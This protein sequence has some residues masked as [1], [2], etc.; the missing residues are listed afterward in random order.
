VNRQS[1]PSTDSLATSFESTETPVA[2]ERTVVLGLSAALYGLLAWLCWPTL[3]YALNAHGD[4]SWFDTF[5]ALSA[6]DA[7]THVGTGFYRPGANVFFWAVSH[8]PNVSA[9]RFIMLA[10]FL[11][12]VGYVQLDATVRGRSYVDGFGAALA[13]S[14]TPSALSV[15]CWL[16]AAPVSLCA[17]AILAY[18]A[19]A[20][21]AL[22]A[23]SPR[24]RDVW[25]ALGALGV[26]LCFY[27][28]AIFA[29]L[30]VVAYQRLLAPR[31]C[32]RTARWLHVG[33]AC[34]VALYLLAQTLVANA[35]HFWAHE[36]PLPLL[37]SS[38][39]Y[40]MENYYLFFNPFDTFGVSIPDRSGDHTTENAV[41]W[42]LMAGGFAVVW[43]CRKSDPLAAFSGLWFSIFLLPVGS[44]FHFEG[45]PIAEQHLY[46]PLMGVAVGGVRLFTRA[47][48][49][50]VA[51]I[52]NKPLRVGVEC[53]I[54]VGLL[55][56]LAPLV[57][58]CTSIVASWKD[59]TTLYTATLAHYPDNVEV[60]RA[61]TQTVSEQA[62][63]APERAENNLTPSPWQ[64]AL[65]KLLMRAEPDTAAS[66][67]R[68]GQTLL[69]GDQYTEASSA[70]SRAFVVSKTRRDQL[71]AGEAL[72]QALALTELRDQAAALRRRLDALY[73]AQGQASNPVR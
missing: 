64:Q 3:G 45:S 20:R 33:A 9:W 53:V 70:L 39:R 32:A 68:R 46:I 28:L 71:T 35:Q 1:I 52:R 41:C 29:P 67:L 36:Q 62:Q 2:P 19:F 69:R 54:T 61:L 10:V 34:C 65:D 6:Q 30:V 24:K 44:V 47:V 8:S 58:Q 51:A 11:L 37:A 59:A 23:A 42:L 57:D 14:M 55:W 12:T 31:A 26:A 48:E 38:M 17:V 4:Q 40:A 27:E 50:G 15:V 66:L 5:R 22:D 73:A 49:R 13:F 16:S 72:A 63:S 60:L 18:V 56:S 7:L 21:R 25:C 43:L